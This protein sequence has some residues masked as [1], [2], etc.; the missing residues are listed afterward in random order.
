MGVLILFPRLTDS[1]TQNR[2]CRRAFPFFW[3]SIV[4]YNNYGD[5][6]KL[7]FYKFFFLVRRP[8]AISVA[9]DGDSTGDTRESGHL[10]E[11]AKLMWFFLHI[12][13]FPFF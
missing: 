13:S 10:F 11:C 12:F 5:D 7:Y 6:S 9:T 1:R 2:V 4:S 8:I 3:F